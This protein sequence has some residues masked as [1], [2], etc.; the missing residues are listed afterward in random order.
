[1]TTM[2]TP[3]L[4]ARPIRL[5]RHRLS[6]HSHRV[7]LFLSILGLPFE[8]IDVAF[9][10]REQK[11][12]AFLALNRFGQVPVIEDGDVV[13]ADSNAILVYLAGR[14]DGS[15]T[16]LPRDPIGAARVQVWLSVAAGPLAS[17]PGVA[18]RTAV[19]NP[20]SI[21]EKAIAA[22]GEL[23]AIVE[24]ALADREYLA[25][26]HPTI[27]D[28]AIYS[29]AAHA[30]EGGVSL[31]PHRHLRAWL[32]RIEALPGFVPMARTPLERPRHA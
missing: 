2:T 10:R 31:E 6:G 5:H 26:S 15:G 14:Y 30:P 12:P 28:L 18:R 8:P 23:F 25:A 3:S 9:E 29:Y 16:W 22:A 27:A 21:D 32:G 24:G 7:E 20:G 19:F 11:A 13:L 4:P 17:G 1:M